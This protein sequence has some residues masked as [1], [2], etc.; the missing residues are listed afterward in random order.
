MPLFI[1]PSRLTGKRL[2]TMP[3]ALC[4]ENEE[5]AAMLLARAQQ[6]AVEESLDSVLLQDSRTLWTEAWDRAKRPCLLAAAAAG[7]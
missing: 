4:A 5:A 7:K 2:M 1:V 6:I 3:G